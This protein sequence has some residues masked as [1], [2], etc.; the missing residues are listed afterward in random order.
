VTEFEREA[1]DELYEAAAWL[2]GLR[3]RLLG[4]VSTLPESAS[5][6]QVAECVVADAILPAIRDLTAAAEQLAESA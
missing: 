5:A 3:F 4:V 1:Q 6:R 2:K